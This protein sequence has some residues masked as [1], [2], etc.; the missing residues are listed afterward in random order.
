MRWFR[1]KKLEK[2]VVE[3]KTLL[4]KKEEQLKQLR[5]GVHDHIEVIQ[6]K[7][8]YDGC[9]DPNKLWY[10]LEGV[11]YHL[12]YGDN[13]HTPEKFLLEKFK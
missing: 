10:A 11:Q 6:N 12:S 5:L 7:V 4:E 1:D 13:E 9:V 3:L 8:S 2:E